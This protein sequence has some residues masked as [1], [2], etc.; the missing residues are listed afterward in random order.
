M[1]PKF[2]ARQSQDGIRT[3]KKIAYVVWILAFILV[4]NIPANIP[5]AWQGV[6]S[7]L[8]THDGNMM[9]SNDMI[10][11]DVVEAQEKRAIRGVVRGAVD[12]ELAAFFDAAAGVWDGEEDREFRMTR[13]VLEILGKKPLPDFGRKATP[14]SSREEGVQSHH[15]AQPAGSGSVPSEGTGQEDATSGGHSQIALVDK[16]QQLSN[17]NEVASDHTT[18]LGNTAPRDEARRD[19]LREL[20]KHHLGERISDAILKQQKLE[21]KQVAKSYQVAQPELPGRTCGGKRFLR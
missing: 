13:E 17:D 8:T 2:G 14:A 9:D 21:K 16:H 5:R 12:W 19:A 11:S 1:P 4:F 10:W 3:D 6:K 18:G 15:G 7:A 20:L